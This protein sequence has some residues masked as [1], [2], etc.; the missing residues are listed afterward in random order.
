MAMLDA[1]CFP[2]LENDQDPM[3]TVVLSASTRSQPDIFFQS[4]IT[5]IRSRVIAQTSDA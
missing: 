2:E 5:S 3:R 4:L 1:R